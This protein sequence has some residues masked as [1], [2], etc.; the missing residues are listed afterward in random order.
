[1]DTLKD[2]EYLNKVFLKTRLGKFGS[3]INLHGQKNLSICV[4]TFN[5]INHLKQSLPN[6]IYL[7]NKYNLEICVSDNYSDD[8]TSNLSKPQHEKRMLGH[9][10]TN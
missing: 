1:M 6:L 8:G 2:R 3:F 4:P 9:I 10:E 5:R 7:A